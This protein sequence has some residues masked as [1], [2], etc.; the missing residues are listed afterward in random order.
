MSLSD[1]SS[2]TISGTTTT[3]P[4]VSTGDRKAVYQSGDETITLTVSHLPTKGKGWRRMV[5]IDTSKIAADPF[6]TDVNNEVSMS[7]YV[8]IE[9]P[10]DGFSPTE[11]LAVWKGLSGLL[12]ASS[13]A[14][15]IKVLGG[16]S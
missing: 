2:V 12:T 6:E 10:S 15:M 5:R 9:T 16:E 4:R 13:D 8:V 14:A 3:L 7:A 1:P 11:A